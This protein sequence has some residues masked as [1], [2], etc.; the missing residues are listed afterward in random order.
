MEY[1]VKEYLNNSIVI[2]SDKYPNRL[3]WL[4]NKYISRNNKINEILG[5]HDSFDISDY[6]IVFKQNLQTKRFD[7]INSDMYNFY[8]NTDSLGF[9]NTY[10]KNNP[11][12]LKDNK[13]KSIEYNIVIRRNIYVDLSKIDS[14]FRYHINNG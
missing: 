11:I 4:Y 6:S 5:Q 8:D 7:I 12:Y 2:G 3:Y 13:V 1:L 14:Y 10:L 9:I